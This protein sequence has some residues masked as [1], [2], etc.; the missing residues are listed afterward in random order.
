M[1][2]AYHPLFH[3][4]RFLKKS[5]AAIITLGTGSSLGPEGPAVE[6]GANL[7]RLI[8]DIFPPKRPPS[9]EADPKEYSLQQRRLLLACGTAAGVSA[10]FNAPLAGAFFVLEILQQTFS[11]I[12]KTRYREAT[13]QTT[14]PPS[15]EAIITPT[16][17]ASGSVSAILLSSVLSALVC[18][19][20]LGEHLHLALKDYS[21]NTP[22][23][24]L[25]LYLLLGATSGLAAFVF[26]QMTKAS[27]SL[28]QGKLGPEFLRRRFARMPPLA[29]PAL[30]GLICGVIGL[31]FPQILF[32]GF[33]TINIALA[34]RM[35]PTLLLLQLLGIKMLTTAVAAGSGL[36]GGTFAPSLFL[37]GM[38]GASF[39]NIASWLFENAAHH[40]TSITL[41]S[42]ILQMA[43]LPAY[44]MVGA[45]T[46]LAAVF[47]AP[48]TASLLLFEMT[49][50]YGAIL[51]LMASTGVAAVVGDI[52][53]A[54]QELVVS[55]EVDDT[56][57]AED[58]DKTFLKEKADPGAADGFA[59]GTS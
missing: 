46:V 38:V 15:V 41:A 34:N 2:K 23:L 39:H 22:L 12:D 57:G 21:I 17:T 45:A 48:L 44:T 36:V 32:N 50:D 27:Q 11:S 55:G 7:S 14:V 29:K 10:G 56:D 47:R 13:Q 42:P 43:D 52:L 31:V 26:T 58:K 53:E 16:L 54:K 28:F 49:R 37:G 9:N 40:G 35:L 25:P 51:P 30:G 19:A 59:N 1:T 3:Q 24:E 20:L 5:F 33:D 6:I 8:T 18:Q 4:F